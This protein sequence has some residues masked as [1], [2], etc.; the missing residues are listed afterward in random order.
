MTQV[1]DDML[2]SDR[3]TMILFVGFSAMALLLS[4]IGIYGV[5]N[6]FV[7]QRSH[8][9]AIRTA[10]GASRTR[11]IASVLREGAILT[12]LGVAGGL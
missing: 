6:F 7:S 8:E 2:S 10:L 11:T 12:I 4:A 3:F 5:M 1:R 9:L